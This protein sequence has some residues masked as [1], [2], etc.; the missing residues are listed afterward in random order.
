MAKFVNYGKRSVTLPAG[1]KDLIDLL[2]PGGRGKV[3]SEAEPAPEIRQERFQRSGL[4]QIGRF[5]AMLVASSTKAFVLL[6]TMRDDCFP[7]ALCAQQG[8]PV[9]E[10]HL[11]AEDLD[12][13][14]AIRRF[15]RRVGVKPVQDLPVPEVF[16]SLSYQMPRDA[17][18]ITS[19]VDGLM[20]RVYGLDDVAGLR[21]LYYE[22]GKAA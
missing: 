9:V 13:A 16:K 21:F 11:C 1:C 5:I 19:V 4:L 2:Q 18:D 10:L 17:R 14:R 15:L 20:R 3:A 8:Q 7:L 6:I 22:I 12:R